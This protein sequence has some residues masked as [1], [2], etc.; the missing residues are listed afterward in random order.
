MVI[1]SIS[2]CGLCFLSGWAS[3]EGLV[4]DMYNSGTSF[5]LMTGTWMGILLTTGYTVR[6]CLRFFSGGKFPSSFYYFGPSRLI[7][8]A[9]IFPL[10]LLTVSE[11][12][13]FSRGKPIV[14]L[15]IE[16]NNF[17]GLLLLLVFGC[18]LGEVA[19]RSQ[20]SFDRL[21]FN[22][23]ALR[24]LLSRST[25]MGTPLYWCERSLGQALRP[26]RVYKLANKCSPGTIIGVNTL[27][28]SVMLLL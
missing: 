9:S 12:V 15:V 8:K 11:G 6:L 2:L 26:R 5:L 14:S 25:T 20:L 3:K 28:L 24:C 10:L 21:Q 16:T 7:L 13:L 19:S 27:L 4:T 22:V 23:A 1:C 17:V 18:V